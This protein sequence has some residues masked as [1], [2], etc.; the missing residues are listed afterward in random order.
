MPSA[1]GDVLIA[2]GGVEV[3][4][5]AEALE[6]ERTGQETRSDGATPSG[7]QA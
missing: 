2:H 4:T 7:N 6:T 3:D 5:A 1:T